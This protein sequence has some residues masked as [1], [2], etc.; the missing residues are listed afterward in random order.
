MFKVDLASWLQSK[1]G[2]VATGATELT[3]DLKIKPPDIFH[4]FMKNI[5]FQVGKI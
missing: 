4:V 2:I 5:N 3:E 1:K